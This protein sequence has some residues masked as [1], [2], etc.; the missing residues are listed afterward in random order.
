MSTV[1]G[2]SHVQSSS[3][4]GAVPF[5]R[6]IALSDEIAVGEV[7]QADE[8]PILARAGF[9][10][11][12]NVQPDGEVMRLA[13]AASLQLAAAAAGLAYVHLP[14]ESRLPSETRIKGFAEAM[15]SM[16]RPIYA[17]CYSG[18]R[19]AAAWALAVAPQTSPAK[20]VQALELAGFDA[21]SLSAALDRRHAGL[22]AFEQQPAVPTTPVA[23]AGTVATEAAKAPEKASEAVL[24]VLPRAA[25]DGGFAVP[26]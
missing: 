4:S 17:Y 6:P 9:R 26:G 25:S 13:D 5:M 18:G 8:I 14:I 3:A 1:A 21:S 23:D 7:P 2:L 20:I 22:E 15:A 10:S 11:L 16:P 12:I 24:I 19:A